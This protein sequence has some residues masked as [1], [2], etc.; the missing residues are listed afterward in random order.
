MALGVGPLA[1]AVGFFLTVSISYVLSYFIYILIEKNTQL[2][3]K[4]VTS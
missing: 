3:V 1:L 2:F 4:R